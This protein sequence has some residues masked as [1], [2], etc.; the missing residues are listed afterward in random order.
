MFKNI[1]NRLSLIKKMLILFI[2]GI[3][4]PFMIQNSFYYRKLENSVQTEMLQRMEITLEDKAMKLNGNLSGVITLS[5]SYKNNQDI[6]QALDQS[7]NDHKEYYEVYQE[8]ITPLLIAD[9]PYHLQVRDIILYTD[10]PTI[11]NG[12][13]V[14]YLTEE[15]QESELL[16]GE[17]ATA[18]TYWGRDAVQGMI[19]RVSVEAGRLKS[20]NK[21][22]ISIIR[23]LDYYP[24]YAQYKKVLRIDMNLDYLIS[25]LDNQHYFSNMI[26]VDDDGRILLADH[27]YQVNSYFEYFDETTLPEETVILS[28]R[29]SEFPFT[30]LGFYDYTIISAT[31]RETRCEM[32]WVMG[33]SICVA[34]ICMLIITQ[35][36]T[37]RTKA[38]VDQSKQIAKG[39]FIQLENTTPD[40]DEIS[41]LQ[42]SINHMSLQLEE[43]ITKEYQAKL[44]QAQLEKETTQAKLL[45]LQ[46]QVNPHF[47]FNALECIRL[48]ALVKKEKET[49]LMIKYMSRMFRHLI[50]WNQDI[51]LLEDDLK[52]LE[53]FLR[54]QKYRFEDD[55]KYSIEVE[56]QVRWCKV[57][58]LIIQP[59]VENA[60]VHGVEAINNNRE[61]TIKISQEGSW[62]KIV[63]KDNGGGFGE[64]RL[65]ELK[66]YLQ[67]GSALKGSIG[68]CNVYQRL[69]L[70]YNDAFSFDIDSQVGIG[71]ICTIR[72][73]IEYE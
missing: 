50:N 38:V 52:F 8:Q 65:A 30:V 1:L 68:L 51:I 27:T 72:I 28:K 41:V 46:S 66:V 53:E 3:L 33:G 47:M 29:L 45:A 48:K 18:H 16:N 43:L 5:R 4:V 62:M 60:C 44:V 32:I 10:N 26:V 63:V 23:P 9:M 36:I 11:M 17:I 37:R 39:N 70:Y 19:L 42:N 20:G 7:Y 21:R 56:E 69:L 55:F 57:P 59:L 40:G 34:T 14:R 2:G 12:N 24:Q 31:F 71:T 61:V 15:E 25:L 6:Y 35:N 13:Y 58:K 22:C 67:R 64:E 73:P 49:A 54:I